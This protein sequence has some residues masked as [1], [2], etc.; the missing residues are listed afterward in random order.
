MIFTWHIFIQIVIIVSFWTVTYSYTPDWNEVEKLAEIHPYVVAVLDSRN[1]YIC[2]GFSI[3]DRT[4]VTAGSCLAIP[5]VAVAISAVLGD[6]IVG[7]NILR[8]SHTKLHKAFS[9]YVSQTQPSETIMNS[10]VALIYVVN[11]KLDYFTNAAVIGDIDPLQ[12]RKQTLAV[13]GFGEIDAGTVVLQR[14]V[15]IQK[16]CVNPQWFYCV[17]GVES[18]ET[19]YE[20]QFGEGGPVVMGS[21]VVAI[22]GAPCGA[23]FIPHTSVKY[24][25]FTVAME[26]H[27][28]IRNN[29]DNT[30]KPE[31]KLKLIMRNN[32]NSSAAVV[33]Y[34]ITL[35]IV[36]HL[37]N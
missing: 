29:Q 27:S 37:I 5:P 12:L 30:T 10:N 4:V 3:T 22:A 14:Q 33:L 9:C 26:Y 32:C 36:D 24:N 1:E 6:D 18:S 2:T 21:K 28:W 16:T 8:V 19:T 20:S 31:Q 13:I 7:K 35:L 34:I 17:C 25:I 23:L 15:Y 11:N